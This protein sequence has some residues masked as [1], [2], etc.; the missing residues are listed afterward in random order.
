MLHPAKLKFAEGLLEGLSRKEAMRQVKPDY[1]SPTLIREANRYFH[2]PDV[3]V[4]LYQ[5]FEELRAKEIAIT[6]LVDDMSHTQWRARMASRDQFFK[7]AGLYANKSAPP[8]PKNLN[9]AG[10]DPSDY[11][12]NRFVA[13]NGRAPEDAKELERYKE[14]FDIEAESVAVDVFSSEQNGTEDP[15]KDAE[16]QDVVPGLDT[17]E[18]ENG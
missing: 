8:A 17:G 14:Q 13:E 5:R 6:G 16:N 7:L 11:W 15:K 10:V 9:Q 1:D 2:D 18:T 12:T 4:Y 3:Q